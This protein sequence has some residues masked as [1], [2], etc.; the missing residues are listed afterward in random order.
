M[1]QTDVLEY[2]FSKFQFANLFSLKMR[3]RT[4]MNGKNVNK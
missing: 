1:D 4:K 2:I 3:R